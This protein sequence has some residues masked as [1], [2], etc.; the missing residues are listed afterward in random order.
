MTYV[1]T[2]TPTINTL[3]T[4]FANPSGTCPNP[5]SYASTLLPMTP[6]TVQNPRGTYGPT[7]TIMFFAIGSNSASS[8]N[9][10]EVVVQKFGVMTP[11]GT[12]EFQFAPL[13]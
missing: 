3:Y 7:E 5:S 9:S 8:V 10:V 12:Q 6:S 11:S 1:I 2:A 4:F 13:L